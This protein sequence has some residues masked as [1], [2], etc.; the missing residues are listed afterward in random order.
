MSIITLQEER[1]I[2]EG[3]LRALAAP[4][5]LS[6]LVWYLAA[7][8]EGSWLVA[9]VYPTAERSVSAKRQ[10]GVA[11]RGK[12]DAELAYEVA[13]GVVVA[14][15]D[16]ACDA[17]VVE[18]VPTPGPMDQALARSGFLPVAYYR[19]STTSIP[20]LLRTF[21]KDIR[22]EPMRATGFALKPLVAAS[23]EELATLFQ[24]ELGRIPPHVLHARDVPDVASIIDCSRVLLYHDTVV[25]AV[26]A[27]LNGRGVDMQALVCSE[28][29]REH[30]AFGWMLQEWAMSLEDHADHCVFSYSERNKAM[31]EIAEHM[32]A[33]TLVRQVRR[34]YEIS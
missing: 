34:W 7:E 6:D 10:W 4:V 26:I 27:R 31:M 17:L 24:E 32:N 13:R 25:A 28:D 16:C 33:E 2:P 20:N 12:P 18:P 5:V 29:W 15:Q 11:F 1:N 3:V 8:R 22:S 23:Q 21:S 9:T 14:A 19:T 30:Q